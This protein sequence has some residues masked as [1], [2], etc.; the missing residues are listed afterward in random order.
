[1]EF[2]RRYLLP[3][4]FQYLV[5]V[6]VGTTIVFISTRLTPADPVQHTIEKI[7]AQG[8]YM[9]PRVVEDFAKT[10]RELYGLEGNVF[11]QYL[12]LWRRLL[13]LD[14]GRSFTYFPTPVMQLIRSSL[15]WT[16]GLLSLSSIMAWT[17]GTI[18]GGLAGYAGRERWARWL[19]GAVMVIR[20]IPYYIVALIALILFA[21]VL[22][23]FPISG[24]VSM[25]RKATVNLAFVLSVLQHGA[26]PA[27]S[28]IVGGIGTWFIQMKSLA[29][30]IV[31][32]DYVTFARAGGLSRSRLVFQYTI[33]NGMLPQITGLALSLGQLLSGALV[34][35]YVFSYPGV[36]VLLYQ[37][38]TQGDYNL[39][40]GITMLSIF[41]IATGVLVIDLI[42][43]LFDP[44][45]RYR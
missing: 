33:R 4:L 35:E 16:L 20:P 40:M 27:L 45:V 22:P 43:P 21:Y 32:E 29:S 11:Q 26:L 25:G 13:V 9:D 7:S 28:L 19:E 23:I 2:L 39:T 24:S 34:V 5:V 31:A 30:N 12:S 37:A 38:I 3:R 36:G 41:A 6:F 14:F 15:P 44:R 10:L 8:G 42:Y 1:V 18:L 17:I